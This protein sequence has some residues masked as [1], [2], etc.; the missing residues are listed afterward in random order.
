MQ[1]DEVI[2]FSKQLNKLIIITR[3]ENGATAIKGEEIYEC[4]IKKS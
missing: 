3:G 2:N 1:P 4:G